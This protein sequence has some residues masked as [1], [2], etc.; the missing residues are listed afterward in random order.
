[1]KDLNVLN[2]FFDLVRSKV[3][4]GHKL[5]PLADGLLQVAGAADGLILQSFVLAEEPQSPR[6]V[7]P[8]V[9]GGQ[10]LLLLPDP[11]LLRATH[12]P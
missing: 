1:M 11:T 9:L 6:Q 7:P 10:D 4:V 8:M 2:P 5:L 12:K 3:V